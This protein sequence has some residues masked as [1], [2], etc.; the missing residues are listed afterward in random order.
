MDRAGR[1]LA[2]CLIA[3]AGISGCGG[4]ADDSLPPSVPSISPASDQTVP[5]VEVT[6]TATSTGPQNDT[7][8]YNWSFGDGGTATGSTAS[9]VYSVEGN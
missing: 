2:I 9:H 4:G 1:A 6:F 5:G 3:V 8:E 7:V